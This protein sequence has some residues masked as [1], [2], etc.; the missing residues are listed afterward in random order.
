MAIYLYCSSLLTNNKE[1]DKARF[2]IY[3]KFF[4]MMIDIMPFPIAFYQNISNNYMINFN[5][6]INERNYSK[7]FTIS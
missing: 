3:K 4:L 7:D 5:I 6:F 1:K 2:F